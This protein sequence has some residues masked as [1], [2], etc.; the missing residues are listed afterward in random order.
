MRDGRLVLAGVQLVGE[1]V[2]RVWVS[3]EKGYIEDGLG[4]GDV[5]TG[6]I[7]VESSLGRSKVRY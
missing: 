6:E 2:E 5:E 1:D 3:A 7:G 4:F